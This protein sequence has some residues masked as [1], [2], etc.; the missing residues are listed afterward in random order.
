MNIQP[1]NLQQ[2]EVK[3]DTDTMLIG[4]LKH[5]GVEAEFIKQQEG[6]GLVVYVPRPQL[7]KLN[8]NPENSE[9]AKAFV[10]SMLYPF[11]EM[12]KLVSSGSITGFAIMPAKELSNEAWAHT[13][14][15]MLGR[16]L[17]SLCNGEIALR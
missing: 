16:T 3:V 6:R 11:Q 5:N 9:S 13:A 15:D 17:Q 14:T 10:T 12:L 8:G 4:L 1:T 2:P 7:E